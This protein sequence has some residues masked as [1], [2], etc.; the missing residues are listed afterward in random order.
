[1]WLAMGGG[2]EDAVTGIET[3]YGKEDGTNGEEED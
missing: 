3:E 1:M 2:T